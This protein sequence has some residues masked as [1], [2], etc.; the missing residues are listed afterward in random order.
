MA[1]FGAVVATTLS[2]SSNW[3]PQTQFPAERSSCRSRARARCQKKAHK[4]R[5]PGSE[6]ES[7]S[8][9]FHP[10]LIYHASAVPAPEANGRRRDARGSIVKHCELAGGSIV[11]LSIVL[12]REPRIRIGVDVI[13]GEGATQSHKPK[14][15]AGS[16]SVI[17]IDLVEPVLV[18]RGD[19]KVPV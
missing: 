15:I 7:L 19:D 17:V 3:T 10:Q 14:D 18:S 1:P 12:V 13:K 8:C 16:R 5:G 6:S 4:R 11:G 2:Q 9:W